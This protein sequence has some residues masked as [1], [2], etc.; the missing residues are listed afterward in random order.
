[1][2]VQKED[3]SKRVMGCKSNHNGLGPTVRLIKKYKSCNLTI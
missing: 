3:K 1:M 2:D